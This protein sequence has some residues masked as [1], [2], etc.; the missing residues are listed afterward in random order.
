MEDSNDEP[1]PLSEITPNY[2]NYKANFIISN[3]LKW[4]VFRLLLQ[5]LAREV[6]FSRTFESCI[7]KT[8]K[9]ALKILKE[10]IDINNE[11]K[12]RIEYD[13]SMQITPIFLEMITFLEMEPTLKNKIYIIKPNKNAHLNK[14]GKMMFYTF[15]ADIVESFAKYYG[16]NV[17][18]ITPEELPKID[19][20]GSF[21][22]ANALISYDLPEERKALNIPD[23]IKKLFK[24]ENIKLKQFDFSFLCSYE[25]A[26]C[27]SEIIRAY[28]LILNFLLFDEFE[29]CELYGFDHI[30][31]RVN[32]LEEL[33]L[34]EL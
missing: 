13:L 27:F 10:K 11:F 22:F 15:G 19:G 16:L 31:A 30:R 6:N 3:A 7:G 4:P 20:E 18:Q 12:N 2:E 17:K 23:F 8:D 14:F 1:P 21:I 29:Y 24:N 34:P 26:S 33:T 5:T 32:D 9:E 25:L 28:C